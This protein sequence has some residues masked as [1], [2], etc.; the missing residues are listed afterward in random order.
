[1][2]AS[3]L[4]L[5][6]FVEL[7]S[8]SSF[9]EAIRHLSWKQM[10]RFPHQYLELCGGQPKLGDNSRLKSFLGQ[11]IEEAKALSADV[12][13]DSRVYGHSTE[14]KA[15]NLIIGKI[16]ELARDEF[17]DP[18]RWRR[19]GGGPRTLAPEVRD[20]SRHY[21][22]DVLSSLSQPH[23]DITTSE[24]LHIKYWASIQLMF[25]DR[26]HFWDIAYL[27]LTAERELF[28]SHRGRT[29]I[30]NT[31]V[32]YEVGRDMFRARSRLNYSGDKLLIP[33]EWTDEIV[34]Q[35]FRDFR[36]RFD[37]FD[38]VDIITLMKRTSQGRLS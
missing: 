6:Q 37:A 22:M 5:A 9:D 12:S 26:P 17:S 11:K 14:Q 35:A 27:F 21:M 32:A 16:V 34:R 30:S 29:A 28:V 24:L 20:E 8:H 13:L 1:M 31:I 4:T 23:L 33:F 19:L 3:N 2:V 10:A 38:S 15:V 18:S 7:G 36:N 25:S